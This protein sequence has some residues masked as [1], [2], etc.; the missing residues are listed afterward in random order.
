M[1]KITLEDIKEYLDVKEQ[2]TALK[3]LEM[4]YRRHFENCL[5][6]ESTDKTG[7]IKIKV[8]DYEIRLTKTVNLSVDQE[9]IADEIETLEEYEEELFKLK[10]DISESKFRKFKEKYGESDSVVFSIVTE[11]PGTPKLEIIPP[12][13]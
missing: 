7:K 12:K 13:D 11:K 5:E 9:L 1:P 2:M 8:G 4:K 3:E 10:Y 6:S